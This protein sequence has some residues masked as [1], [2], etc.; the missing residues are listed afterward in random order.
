MV[1]TAGDAAQEVLQAAY[2]EYRAAVS[3]WRA[4]AKTGSAETGERVADRLLR[5][6]V[7]LYRALITSGWAPPLEVRA[8]LDRDA[9]LVD[10]PP[11][12]DHLLAI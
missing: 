6:R 10:A 8:Q 2:Q 12:F 9:A 1:E 11:D 3:A 4:A 7:R 5:A